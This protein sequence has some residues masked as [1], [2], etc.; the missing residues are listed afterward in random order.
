MRKLQEE[1][2]GIESGLSLIKAKEKELDS[3]ILELYKSEKTK[4]PSY[5]P[6]IEG[7]TFTSR[8]QTNWVYSDEKKVL[9]YLQTNKPELVR[10]KPEIDKVA[11]KKLAQVAG[12]GEVVLDDYNILE[13]V[14]VV[15]DI[16]HSFNLEKESD[17]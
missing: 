16:S 7:A 5:K 12:D 9:E 4:N 15:E 8:R 1:R 14:S 17:V 11:L 13:G 2:R 10:N 6:E 3:T